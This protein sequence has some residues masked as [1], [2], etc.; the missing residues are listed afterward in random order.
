MKKYGHTDSMTAN[1]RHETTAQS[2][3]DVSQTVLAIGRTKFPRMLMKT[4]R[5]L[6]GVDHCMV[7]SLA[8]KKRTRCLLNAGNIAVSNDLGAATRSISIKQT[9]TERPYSTSDRTF[10]LSSCR[11]SHAACMMTAI[12]R[13]SLRTSI[14]LTSLPLRYG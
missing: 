1:E 8:P 13:F 12:V 4:L 7:F 5:R 3:I 9:Q 11:P 6:A 14:S 10:V 2:N